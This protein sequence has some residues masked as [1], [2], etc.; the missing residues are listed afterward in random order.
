[1]SS[2][3]TNQTEQHNQALERKGKELQ[4]IV[5]ITTVVL[6]ICAILGGLFGAK[7]GDRSSFNKISY[8]VHASLSIMQLVIVVFVI[9]LV[10]R[11]FIFRKNKKS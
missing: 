4:M 3:N 8:W 7:Y 10:V 5:L 6:S 11:I 2:Q 9:S 1:M